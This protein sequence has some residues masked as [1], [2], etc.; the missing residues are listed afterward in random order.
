[1]RVII[2]GGGIG[3]NAA[4]LS[5]HAVGITD[6]DVF[7]RV[8]EFHATVGQGINLLPHGSR[9]LIELG[10]YEELEKTA[11]STL[12]TR[13][14]NR[15]GQPIWSEP[16]G[17]AAGH[18]WPQFSVQRGELLRILHEAVLVRLGSHRFHA[19]VEV[20][21]VGQ[22]HRRV[23]ADFTDRSTGQP[24]ERQYAD[25]LIAADGARSITRALLNPDEKP[26]PWNGHVIYRG[27]ALRER[28]FDGRTMTIIGNL[29][30][31]DALA[32]TTYSISRPH[33][34][35]SYSMVNWAVYAKLE[36][37]RPAP[38]QKWNHAGEIEEAAALVEDWR[39]DFLDVP[40]LIRSTTQSIYAYP[41]VD[42]DPLP[43][44]SHGR[45]TLLGDAAHP[46]YPYGSQ[47]AVQT[48][49]DGRVLAQELA[50]ESDS[51][52]ALAAYDASRRPATSAVVLANRAARTDAYC[53]ELAHLRSP[54][55][56]DDNLPSPETF[57]RHAR[58]YQQLAGYDP[59]TLSRRTSYGPPHS[60][61]P[62]D[63]PFSSWSG[64]VGR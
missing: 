60:M 20:T 21:A 11:I 50:T 27:N 47:G 22:D 3:G 9:E 57:A 35:A 54:H 7:E 56:I 29:T 26:P 5:L 37:D 41:L 24:T 52:A 58:E 44:W 19:G 34:D 4:A 36:P 13:Y 59:R 32:V 49:V 64:G 2:L 39:F 8:P 43:R 33:H 6:V 30:G 51:I 23:W 25:V 42:R 48:I 55:G 17:I 46:M 63:R 12:R 38:P 61:S 16:R 28:Y 45:I 14:Y 31:P 10:L 40:A 15:H 18:R 53:L 62:T 1:M